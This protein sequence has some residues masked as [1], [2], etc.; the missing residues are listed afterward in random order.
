MA[1]IL[2]DGENWYDSDYGEPPSYWNGSV[3]EYLGDSDTGIYYGGTSM[4]YAGTVHAGDVVAGSITSTSADNTEF[5]VMI[6]GT[7]VDSLELTTNQTY[8]FN[9]TL[10][11]GATVV[12]T[13]GVGDYLYS[14]DA[15]LTPLNAPVAPVA[16][17]APDET[18][19]CMQGSSDNAVTP[20]IKENGLPITPSA[21]FIDQAPAHGTAVVDGSRLLYTPDAAFAGSDSFTYHAIAGGSGSNIA[22]VSITVKMKMPCTG[23]LLEVWPPPDQSYPLRIRAYAVQQPFGYAVAPAKEPD[24]SALTSC[25][26]RL[27]FLLALAKA[28]AHYEHPDANVYAN[29]F[30]AM[31]DRLRAGDHGTRRYVPHDPPRDELRHREDPDPS[32][33]W[34]KS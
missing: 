25:D 5:S 34:I 17:V 10:T 16:P 33:H 3:Y 1:N 28:K 31:L 6:N 7:A 11:A 32:T 13:L 12:I 27:V 19:V 15:V 9:H 22:V 8:T 4:Q 21:L 18:I 14:Q 30:N 23:P 2:S 20:I 24:D 26:A 29:Q